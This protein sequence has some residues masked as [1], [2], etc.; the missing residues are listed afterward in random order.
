ME[1]IK[2]R[3]I[4]KVIGMDDLSDYE[5]RELALKIVQNLLKSIRETKVEGYN[6]VFH[7]EYLTKEE[8]GNGK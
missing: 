3:S 6:V 8:L 1:N 5:K 2:N 7:S 4:S